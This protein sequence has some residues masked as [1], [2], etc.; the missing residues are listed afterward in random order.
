MSVSTPLTDIELVQG[1]RQG[2][3]QMREQLIMRHTPLVRSIARRYAGRGLALDDIIQA[4]YLGLV[5][6]VNR[7][8]PERGVPLSAFAARTIEGEIMHQ[9]RDRGW[10][11]RVPRSLQ[12]L[13]RRTSSMSERLSH[14]LGRAP[15]V[16]ELAEALEVTPEQ[17]A[18]AITA[19]RAYT[20]ES[21]DVTPGGDDRSGDGGRGRTLATDDESLESVADRTTIVKLL[22]TLPMR[23]RRIVA[24]RYFDDL[25]QSEIAD[26][27]GISQMHVSRL[28]RA[29]L[30]SLR[31]ELDANAA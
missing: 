19:Q 21:L 24:L 12:E 11:V 9:F 31:S 3:E 5:Q 6:S 1:I 17:V 29:A 27:L 13:S 15:T 4:G 8:Q 26:R 10:A 28:L 7:Y 25:T 16:E 22:Q 14:K 20:A 30:D 18:E 2:D 23:E